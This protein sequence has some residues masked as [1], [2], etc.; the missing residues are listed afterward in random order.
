MSRP[1]RPSAQPALFD[2][3]QTGQ[4]WRLTA[5]T[6]WLLIDTNAGTIAGGADSSGNPAVFDLK[7][8]NL[9]SFSVGGWRLADNDSAALFGGTSAA[10]TP[11]IF[12]LKKSVDQLWTPGAGGWTL[13]DSVAGTLASGMDSSGNLAVFDLKDNNLYSFDVG[14]WHLA[15]N[16]SSAIYSGVNYNGTPSVF[17]LKKSVDQ[18]WASGTGGWTLVDNVAGSLA[19]IDL[20]GN[21]TVYDLKNNRLWAFVPGGWNLADNE[22]LAI[23]AGQTDDGQPALYDLKTN[24]NIWRFDLTG[25]NFVRTWPHSATSVAQFGS[26]GGLPAPGNFTSDDSA[27]AKSN[28]D[29]SSAFVGAYSLTTTPGNPPAAQV[30]AG[31]S[32]LYFYNTTDQTVYAALEDRFVDSTG[33][34]NDTVLGWWTIA[35]HTTV[36]IVSSIGKDNYS[37]YA[38]TADGSLFWAGNNSDKLFEVSTSVQRMLNYNVSNPPVGSFT[39]TYV[40]VPFLPLPTTAGQPLLISLTLPRSQAGG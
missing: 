21:A 31:S 30:P 27:V 13:A 29:A 26:Q 25:W 19:S 32:P 35:P 8:N 34:T 23:A 3:K 38:Q 14:G 40:F 5:A 24:Y 16:D 1:S 2:L 18:L 11:A 39:Q 22:A 37:F 15:D 17:D 6:G 20:N 33:K 28:A 36:R 4:L 7:G 9:Y 10:G 12:D